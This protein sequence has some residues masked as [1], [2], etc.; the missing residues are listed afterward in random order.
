MVAEPVVQFE[1]SEERV[2]SEHVRLSVRGVVDVRTS[3]RLRRVMSSHFNSETKCLHVVLD[4]VPRMDS[5]GVATL[6]EGVRWS[7]SS[8]NRF[9][10]SGL[11]DSLHDLFAISNLEREFE[12]VTDDHLAG[13]DP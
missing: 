11:N 5:S 2:D 12:I 8:G 6:L 7:R 9:V 3:P 13:V 10:L 1:I 4:E